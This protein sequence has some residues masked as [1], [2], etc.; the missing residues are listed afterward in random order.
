MVMRVT[1]ISVVLCALVFFG[2]PAFAAAD[3]FTFSV[4][5]SG[6]SGSGS[7]QASP[8]GTIPNAEDITGISGVVNGSTIQALIPGSYDPNDQTILTFADSRQF[9]FDNLLYTQGDRFDEAGVLFQLA[10]GEYFN[11]YQDSVLGP[12]YLTLD[13][14]PAYDETAGVSTAAT[15]VITPASTPEPSSLFL[16]A[17]GL[18][19]AAGL[20]RRNHTAR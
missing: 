12:A 7:I 13:G 14:N 3:T 16:L 5:G 19:S 18:A 4:T 17:T 20:L 1:S 9:N 15:I 8:N 11:L 2:F 10:N 6:I